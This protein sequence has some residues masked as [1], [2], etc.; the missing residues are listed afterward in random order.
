VE[1]YG[2]LGVQVRRV[3]GGARVTGLTSAFR[4]VV[5]ALPVVWSRVDEVLEF[6]RDVVTDLFNIRRCSFPLISRTNG[7]EAAQRVE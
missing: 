1:R 4:A 6:R 3:F 5:Q 2:I 7:G